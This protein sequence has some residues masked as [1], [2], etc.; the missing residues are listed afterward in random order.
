VVS[1]SRKAGGEDHTGFMANG[2]LHQSERVWGGWRHSD[3]GGRP[4][5]EDKVVKRIFGWLGIK[6]IVIDVV[7]KAGRI[8]QGRGSREGAGASSVHTRRHIN[9]VHISGVGF[10][11]RRGSGRDGMATREGDMSPPVVTCEHRDT[12]IKYEFA[13]EFIY[14]RRRPAREHATCWSWRRC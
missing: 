13:R 14:L 10:G 5:R 2:Q 8:R 3:Q 6:I 11:K 7:L 12:V 9:L 1:A 4:R